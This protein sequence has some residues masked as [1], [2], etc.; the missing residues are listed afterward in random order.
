MISAELSEQHGGERAGL[1]EADPTVGA[2]RRGVVAVHIE[3]HRR[4]KLQAVEDDCGHA[5]GGQPAP[6]VLRVHPYPLNLDDL[7]GHCAELCFEGDLP[8]A[9]ITMDERMAG[10]DEA[11]NALPVLRGSLRVGGHQAPR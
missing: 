7:P 8:G 2:Q 11:S 9:R 1:L 3:S 6:A 5:R 4:R 10:P